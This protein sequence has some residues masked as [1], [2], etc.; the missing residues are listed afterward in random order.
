MNYFLPAAKIS[1][2]HGKLFILSRIAVYPLFHPAA[3]LRGTEVLNLFKADFRQLSKT[4]E[5]A[6]QAMA[7]NSAAA[8]ANLT[9]PQ[10]RLFS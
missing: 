8:S 4:L 3:A 10:L 1:R 7:K 2:D 9:P 5:L 6:K